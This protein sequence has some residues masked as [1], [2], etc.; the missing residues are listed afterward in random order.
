VT[1]AEDTAVAITLVAEDIY[2]GTLAWTVGTPAMAHSAYRSCFDLYPAANY[3]GSD[4]FTFS[5]TMARWAAYSYGYH[6]C[7]LGE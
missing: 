3:H 4:S 2:P 1:A 6:H 7:H 5:V